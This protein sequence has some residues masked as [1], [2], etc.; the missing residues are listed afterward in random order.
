MAVLSHI[1]E[2][3]MVVYRGAVKRGDPKLPYDSVRIWLSRAVI[4]R[5][6]AQY[7]LYDSEI[8]LNSAV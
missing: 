1:Y 7:M 4:Q 5:S 2:G 3:C 8:G 6:V